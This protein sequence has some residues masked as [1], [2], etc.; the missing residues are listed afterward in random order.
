MTSDP[1]EIR[2]PDF[3]QYI[4]F[5]PA[6]LCIRECIRLEVLSTYPHA[7]PILDVGC[8]DG[9]FARLAFSTGEVWGIDI[10]ANEGRLAQASQAYSQV[11]LGDISRSG[12]PP[13]YFHT[14][15]ANCSLEH[16][17][18][19]DQALARI[20]G[21]LAPGGTLYLFVP[22]QDWATRMR[23]VRVAQRLGLPWL[24]DAI[25]KAIDGI[26]RHHHLYDLDEWKRRA[27]RA[28]FEII[29]ARPI[30]SAAAAMHAFELLLLPSLLGLVVKRL[31][32]RWILFPR[33]RA[34]L[35]V[36]LYALVRALVATSDDTDPSAE[37]FLVLRRAEEG[38]VA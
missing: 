32:G 38:R 16:V 21:A 25:V 28:G 6:A 4:R 24:A 14:C 3:Q 17:P 27:L 8:G 13:S 34:S 37:W 30:G 26:F 12:F 10:D 18:Q 33:L 9:L 29:E 23:A 1:T 35:V 11:I 36:P 7:A 19:L 22:T 31:T 5:T 15:V 2:F 20:H